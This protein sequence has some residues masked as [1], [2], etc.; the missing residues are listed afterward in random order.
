VGWG[1]KRADA[2]K[3]LQHKKGLTGQMHYQTLRTGRGRGGGLTRD[4]LWTDSKG[5]KGACCLAGSA[6][7]AFAHKC[8]WEQQLFSNCAYSTVVCLLSPVHQHQ[9]PATLTDSMPECLSL[10]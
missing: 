10:I 8:I 6:L 1:G 2:D 5:V 9:L 7:R 4:R 3:I